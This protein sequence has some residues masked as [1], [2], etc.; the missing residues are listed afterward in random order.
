MASEM[1]LVQS[2]MVSEIVTEMVS[3]LDKASE[4]LSESKLIDWA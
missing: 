3:E 2:A 1:A 4:M